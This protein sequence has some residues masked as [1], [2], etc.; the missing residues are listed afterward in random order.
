M[1]KIILNLQVSAE[2]IKCLKLF[3]KCT[4]RNEEIHKDDYFML[5]DVP[6]GSDETLRQLIILGLVY[7]QGIAFRIT[8]IGKMVLAKK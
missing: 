2:Q 3:S 8:D 6:H 1:K 5:A 7:S 4:E